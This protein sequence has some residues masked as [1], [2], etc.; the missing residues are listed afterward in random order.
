MRVI[1]GRGCVC[2]VV[3]HDVL[4]LPDQALDSPRVRGTTWKGRPE[5]VRVPYLKTLW[6]GDL[7]SQVA[8]GP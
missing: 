1:P 5:R 8:A 7:C 3:G 2:G 6:L 4:V